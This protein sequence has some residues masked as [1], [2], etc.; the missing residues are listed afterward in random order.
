MQVAHNSF[1]FSFKIW[2]YNGPHIR[3][4]SRSTPLLRRTLVMG[5]R[6]RF[7]CLVQMCVMQ[8][9][10]LNSWPGNFRSDSTDSGPRPPVLISLCCSMTGQKVQSSCTGLSLG[11]SA[12]RSM[13]VV[14]YSQASLAALVTAG[15]TGTGGLA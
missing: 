8:P 5:K 2:F 1:S 11:L 12:C 7:G 9:F 10:L 4:N 6:R 14:R 15:Y 13:G 3:L